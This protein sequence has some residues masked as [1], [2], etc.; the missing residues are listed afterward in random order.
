MVGP[1]AYPLLLLLLLLLLF[2]DY[3]KIKK[4]HTKLTQPLKIKVGL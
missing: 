4:G 1:R 3:K 2:L